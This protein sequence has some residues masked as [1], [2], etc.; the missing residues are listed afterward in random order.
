MLNEVVYSGVFRGIGPW[1]LHLVK[2]FLT[3][4]KLENLACVSISGQRKFGPPYEY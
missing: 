1:F 3:V 2:T 4:K